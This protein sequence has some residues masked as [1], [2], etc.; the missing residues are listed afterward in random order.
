[1]N[2]YCVVVT[3]GARARFFL[4][5]SGQ[6]AKGGPNLIEKSDLINPEG[7]ASGAELF[8]DTRPGRVMAP[9][10]GGG[11]SFDDHRSQH[12]EENERRF[13]KK[14]AETALKAVGDQKAKHLVLVADKRML[15]YL[16]GAFT[17][18]PKAGLEISE[19]P[20]N[21]TKLAPQELHEHL[22]LEQVLPQRRSL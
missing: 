6:V 1:M 5:E 12:H 16:R 13:A 9:D 10:G 11:Q 15:G 2:N 21:L 17:A 14:I 7:V 4:L 19:V 18:S 20:K 8:S 3:D 22:A